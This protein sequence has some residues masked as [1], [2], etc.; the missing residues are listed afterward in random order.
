[1]PKKMDDFD[2]FAQAIQR[3][4]G[5]TRDPLSTRV[6]SVMAAIVDVSEG[7][8]TAGKVYASAIS[9]LEG[10]LLQSAD[11][12][13]SL[14]DSLYT[15]AALLKV[16]TV[17]VRH[18]APSTLQATAVLT[19]RVLRA[20]V[21]STISLL[22]DDE[23][24]AEMI[25]T[26]DGLGATN[27]V[28]QGTCDVTTEVLR[29][30]PHNTDDATVRKLLNET[31]MTLLQDSSRPRTQTAAKESLS[32]LLLQKSPQ[33]HPVILKSTTK[34]ADAMIDRFLKHPSQQGAN[35]S[36][37]ELMGFLNPA[38]AVMDFTHIGGR[39]MTILIDLMNQESLLSSP[40]RPV[41]AAKSRATTLHILTI[42]SILSAILSL[43]EGL[44]QEGE[45]SVMQNDTSNKLDAFAARVLASLVQV[46]S[47]L[48][49]REGV[50]EHDLLESGRLIYGQVMLSAS[51]RLLNNQVHVQVAAK[52]LPLVFQH[53][54]GLSRPIGEDRETSAGESLFTE[55]SQLIRTNLLSLKEANPS[56]HEK[57]T[58]ECLEVFA[59]IVRSPFDPV[60]ARALQP[61]ALL[62]QQ[63]PSDNNAVKES[64]L[65]LV[66]LRSDPEVGDQVRAFVDGA[67]VSLV[68]GIGV[69]YF[70]TAIRFNKLLCVRESKASVFHK[71]SWL[72]DIM[73]GS[74][75]GKNR[76][77]LAFFQNEVLPLVRNFDVMASKGGTSSVMFRSLVVNL[78][79]LFPV[80]CRFPSDIQ[81]T[82]PNSAP[83]LMKAMNDERYPELIIIICNGFD[84]LFGGV[85]KRKSNYQELI[86]GDEAETT[87]MDAE[88]LGAVSAKLLPSLFKL[89]DTLHERCG[90]R[91]GSD[92][93][94][95]DALEGNDESSKITM[96]TGCIAVVARLAPKELVRHLFSRVLQRILQ[97]SQD[98]DDKSILKL[99]SL[100]SL[101]QSLVVSESLE[102]SS[103]ELLF[104]ALKP[105]I[106]TDETP[107]KVQKRAYK[108]LCDICKKYHSF[109]ADA[110]RLKEVTALLSNTSAT[111]QIAARFMR[112]KCLTIVVEGFDVSGKG[113]D[114]QVGHIVF[115]SSLRLRQRKSSHIFLS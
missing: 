99:C 63:M 16:L 59:Y 115:G 31:L 4:R 113:S 86:E 22:A 74:M 58:N 13:D 20:L 18:V 110:S 85:L 8:I 44:E 101:A 11:D 97:T 29:Q 84:E 60:Y 78:W 70:W 56:M 17:V 69:E 64:I 75:V 61:F 105:L 36:M 38:L 94:D 107:A 39:I 19:S 43:L 1:M 34:F 7:E 23:N 5:K 91:E 76:T 21:S 50:A 71:Y 53:V 49:F 12:A 98:R 15:Q 88:V 45:V 73:K 51:Q 95:T 77:L 33:C 108:L 93:M 80:F 81:E 9:T 104:R 114:S 32:G 28:L 42:N 2:S 40:S 54:F 26:K 66:T 35:Q 62:L 79:S 24:N 6:A 10:I 100:L 67:L 82:F 109:I 47:T 55:V 14:L 46:K 83:T 52:L 27:M 30:L 68:E 37:I 112:L 111:S 41:F 92:A 102:D 87:K 106:R 48:V 3:L 96:V 57:C 89:V 65:T 72:F 25:D 103:I 90:T